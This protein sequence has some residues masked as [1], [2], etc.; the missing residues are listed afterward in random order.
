MAKRKVELENIELKPQVIGYSYK[1]KSNFGR[2]VFILIIFLV[3]VYYIND[4]SIF[5]NN[6]LGKNTA[7]SITDLA[8]KNNSNINPNEQKEPNKP[9]KNEYYEVN[10]KTTIE[11]DT[12]T[13]NTFSYSNQK[14]SFIAL[15]NT[16]SSVNLSGKKY[17]LETYDESKNLLESIKVDFGTVAS[18]ANLSLTYDINKDFKYF[19]I[20]EKNASLYPSVEL[21]YDEFNNANMICTKGTETITYTFK[22]DEL[23]KINHKLTRNDI[24]STDYNSTLE[25]T[26]EKINNYSKQ[27]GFKTSLSENQS[28]FEMNV[29]IDLQNA[30]LNNTNEKYYY[31]YKEM[32][33]VVK[34]EMETYGFKCN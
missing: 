8:N 31:A 10:D 7:S 4:V 33:K 27:A 32:P 22:N 16:T 15:N 23:E 18:K 2:Y 19:T 6:L 21:K 29:D 3:V 1:K 34:F 11:L 24:N 17:Y 13:L 5:I 12:I 20:K 26:R 25:S 28:G 14:L 9:V 30:N